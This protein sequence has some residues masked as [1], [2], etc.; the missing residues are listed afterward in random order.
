MS[1]QERGSYGCEKVTVM[2]TVSFRKNKYNTYNNH[3]RNIINTEMLNKSFISLQ[4]L[5]MFLAGIYGVPMHHVSQA[6]IEAICMFC[7]TDTKLHVREIYLVDI[8][9][10]TID[11]FNSVLTTHVSTGVFQ[12]LSTTV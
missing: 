2:I 10:S 7:A 1:P 12:K 5:S 9:A 4:N 3:I 8:S 11:S 6:A